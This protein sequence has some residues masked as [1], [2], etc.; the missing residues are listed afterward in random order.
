MSLTDSS[1]PSVATET[2]LSKKREL[3]S[4]FSPEDKT[5]KK[6]K[7]SANFMDISFEGDTETETEG[8]MMS[9][10]HMLSLPESELQKL[11]EIVR[12]SVEGNVLVSIRSDLR[13][14]IKEAVSEAMDE[15]LKNLTDENKRLSAENVQLEIRIS[16]LEQA[17]DDTEQYS[18]RNSVRIS[19]LPETDSEDTDNLVLKVA[20]VLSIDLS[21]RDIDRSHRIGK[22]G[23]KT[24]RD[25]IVK[26][27]SY[28]ARERLMKNRK[29]LKGSDLD[30]VFVNEDLTK[31]R[32]AILYEARL[33]VKLKEPKLKGAWSSDGKLLIK[34]L[35][36]KVHKI[37]STE[38]LEPYKTGAATSEE[39][40]VKK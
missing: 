22:P 14:L 15:K 4:P 3:S 33:L 31:M 19:N 40:A 16:K 21:P 18:R 17:V 12:P 10:S 11:G 6:T 30:G 37:S 20:D 36:D 38:E 8:I 13:C 34:D 29:N 39:T 7:P 1:T 25:I 23:K 26:F 2:N 35:N 5:T 32:S 24:N 9:Q 28:R 27:T